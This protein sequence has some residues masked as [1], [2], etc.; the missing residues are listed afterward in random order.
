MSAMSFTCIQYSRWRVLLLCLTASLCSC[1]TYTRV[2]DVSSSSRN[3]DASDAGA[4]PTGDIGD[5]RDARPNPDAGSEP[6]DADQLE[7]PSYAVYKLSG[8]ELESTAFLPF[9]SP[10]VVAYVDPEGEATKVVVVDTAT[11][12]N[13]ERDTGALLPGSVIYRDS[14]AETF[15]LTT[16]DFNREFGVFE[17]TFHRWDPASRVLVAV[18]PGGEELVEWY[19]DDPYQSG[20]GYLYHN[21]SK[22]ISVLDLQTGSLIRTISEGR[23]VRADVEEASGRIVFSVEFDTELAPKLMAYDPAADALHLVDEAVA[24][25]YVE[26]FGFLLNGKILYERTTPDRAVMQWDFETTT[27]EVVWNGASIDNDGRWDT[28]QTVLVRAN[29]EQSDRFD[30]S[31]YTADAGERVFTDTRLGRLRE[32]FHVSP[33]GKLVVYERHPDL[34]T[35]EIVVQL[36]DS[37]E[38]F[39]IANEAMVD[40]PTFGSDEPAVAVP[41]SGEKTMLWSLATQK[42]V[43]I[44]TVPAANLRA[45]ATGNFWVYPSAEPQ[46]QARMHAI[47]LQTEETF[48]LASTYP[49][50]SYCPP[51]IA[52]DGA[53]IFFRTSDGSDVVGYLWRRSDKTAEIIVERMSSTS[54]CPSTIG[55]DGLMRGIAQSYPYNTRLAAWR[56][57]QA[58]DLNGDKRVDEVAISED[59]E[60]AYYS[61]RPPD[62]QPEQHHIVRWDFETAELTALAQDAF[63]AEFVVSDGLLAY[64]GIIDTCSL[65]C[66]KQLVVHRDGAAN[67]PKVITD[68]AEEVLDIIGDTVFFR[69]AINDWVGDEDGAGDLKV[70]VP[71]R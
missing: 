45:D 49:Y 7:L 12:T 3:A 43:E 20:Y 27:P 4:D 15:V 41:L 2:I 65:S 28:R 51:Q 57:D 36:L 40:K 30:Y 22:T 37:G 8:G 11:D 47:D 69:A 21:G 17:A 62:G 10:I 32:D 13:I 9:D 52:P 63:G 38:R 56:G 31:V 16:N 61:F 6:D 42:A 23:V 34:S 50:F 59:L 19:E 39:V 70:A 35:T 29:D 24:D 66:P 71:V 26:R 33:N 68:G 44:A 64:T 58:F 5:A 54:A 48:E 18:A 67:T 53:Q 46:Q 55:A 60:S 14:D 1:E 25:G